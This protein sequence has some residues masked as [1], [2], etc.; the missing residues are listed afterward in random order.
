M[1]KHAWTLSVQSFME[2]QH[3]QILCNVSDPVFECRC[4]ESQAIYVEFKDILFPPLQN[5]ECPIANTTNL[6]T[7]LA[8][9]QAENNMLRLSSIILLCTVSDSLF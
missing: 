8:M 5:K 1:S 9:R 4:Y 2:I 6:Y 3:C 7:Y